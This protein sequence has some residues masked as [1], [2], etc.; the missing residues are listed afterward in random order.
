LKGFVW[1]GNR[2]DRRDR[3]RL[4]NGRARSFGGWV[5]WEEQ[6]SR[7]GGKPQKGRREGREGWENAEVERGRVPTKHPDFE[8]SD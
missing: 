8:M 2:W 7:D 4:E 1:P 3:V 5:I 6:K